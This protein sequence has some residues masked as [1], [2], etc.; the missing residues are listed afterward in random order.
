MEV[1]SVHWQIIIRSS[2]SSLRR[3]H[4]IT[5]ITCHFHE[6]F[7][8]LLRLHLLPQWMVLWV[9]VDCLAPTVVRR[10]EDIFVAKHRFL[11][12]EWEDAT[13]EVVVVVVGV[14]AVLVVLIHLAVGVAVDHRVVEN[15]VSVVVVA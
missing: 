11:D 1:Y 2:S 14:A 6:D 10:R 4:S 8:R 5:T 12:E 9:V 3:Y 15:L 7:L 13:I